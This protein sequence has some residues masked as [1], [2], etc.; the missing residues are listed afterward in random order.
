MKSWGHGRCKRMKHISSMLMSGDNMPYVFFFFLK[1]N[2]KQLFLPDLYE[3]PE[4]GN[5][6]RQKCGPILTQCL[7]FLTPFQ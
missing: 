5:T 1:G 2:T 6:F 3:V 7:N 4:F